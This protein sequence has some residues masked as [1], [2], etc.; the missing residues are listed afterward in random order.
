MRRHVAARP[1]PAD[2]RGQLLP[3][4]MAVTARWA[5]IDLEASGLGPSSFPIE[6]GIA[7]PGRAADGVW[8][9]TLRSWLLRPEPRWLDRP[10]AWDPVAEEIHGLS[11]PRLLDEGLPLRQVVEEIDAHLAGCTVNADTGRHGSDAGWLTEVADALGEAW[12]PPRW[13]LHRK[14]GPDLLLEALAAAQLDARLAF[15]PILMRAPQPTHAAAEDAHRWAYAVGLAADL[16]ETPLFGSP[17]DLLRSR[18][19]RLRQV[20]PH[21]RRPRVAAGS[22]YRRRHG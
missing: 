6:L 17:P 4:P 13:R 19:R 12:W 2:Q 18:L 7:L 1:R 11:L 21:D 15:V 8:E 3:P 5:T 9:V 14:S 16:R 10:D 20:I 22:R